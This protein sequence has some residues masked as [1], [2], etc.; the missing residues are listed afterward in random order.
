MLVLGFNPMKTVDAV[1][2]LPYYYRDL[3]VLKHQQKTSATYI[4]FGTP[5]PCLSE[6]FNESGAARG[7]YFHQDLLVAKRVPENST[8]AVFLS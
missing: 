3:Q 1:R 5:Y 6:R 2:G 4:P 7:H 8:V